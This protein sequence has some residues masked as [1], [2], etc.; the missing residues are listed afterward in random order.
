MPWS[1]PRHCSHGHPPFTGS[2]CP[3][4]ASASKARADR[5]RPSARARGYD[6]KWQRES[7]AFLA[8]H[9]FCAA[10]DS[11]AT[12]VDHITPHKGDQHLFWDRGNW[13][14]LCTSCH[15]RKTA[16]ED[17]GFGHP[18]LSRPHS[19]TSRDSHVT[20]CDEDRGEGLSFNYRL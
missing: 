2:R 12:V 6:S 4:C 18:V 19:V 15:S 3:H 16:R 9:P 5:N 8:D 11:P 13:Q 20:R 17:G 7:K 1:S 10:C 14:P